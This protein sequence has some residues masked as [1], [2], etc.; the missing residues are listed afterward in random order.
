ME[1]CVSRKTR[2]QTRMSFQD[3]HSMCLSAAYRTVYFTG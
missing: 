2:D 3:T 1:N